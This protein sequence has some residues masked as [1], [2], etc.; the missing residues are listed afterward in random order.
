LDKKPVRVLLGYVRR[1]ILWLLLALVMLAGGQA[2]TLVVPTELGNAVEAVIK[3]QA[4]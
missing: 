3:A 2:A 1:K 4:E